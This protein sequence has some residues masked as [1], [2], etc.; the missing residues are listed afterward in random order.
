MSDHSVLFVEDE[1]LLRELAACELEDAGYD[2][3]VVESGEEALHTLDGDADPF[4]AVVTDVNLG[5]GADGWDVGKRARELDCGIP[6][7]YMSGAS[8]HEWK[9][10]GVSNSVFLSK[11]FTPSQLTSAI[12][13]LL[14]KVGRHC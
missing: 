9:S 11:P 5:A 7:I 2:V 12:S 3:V 1:D 4:C 13:W 14:K 10:K 8:G 6:V